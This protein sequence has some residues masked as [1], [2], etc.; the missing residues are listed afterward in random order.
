[1]EEKS[2]FWLLDSV[3]DAMLITDSTGR[4]LLA[5]R[6]VKSLFGYRSIG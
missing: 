6:P 4:I 5:N 3:A 1:M 2:P